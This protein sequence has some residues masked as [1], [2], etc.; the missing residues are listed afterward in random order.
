[1]HTSIYSLLEWISVSEIN[2]ANVVVGSYE[3]LL[4][5]K[6]AFIVS[7]ENFTR[8]V[9]KN[10]SK[11][12]QK[13]MAVHFISSRVKCGVRRALLCG[14]IAGTQLETAGNKALR[15]DRCRSNRFDCGV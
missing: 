11:Q 5:D 10:D 4:F 2:V 15:Q 7:G 9:R 12:R 13:E 6:K 3:L 14:K 8:I 1:M